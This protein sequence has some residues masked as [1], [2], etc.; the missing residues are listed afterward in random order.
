MK[1][2][3]KILSVL[4]TIYVPFFLLMGSIRIL[5]NPFFLDHEYGL[6]TFPADDFGFTTV[7]RLKWGKLSLEYLINNESDEY[8]GT[9]KFDRW[10][11]AV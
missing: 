5:I 4:V 10:F 6:P 2:L 11:P 1:I 9:L 7:D 8:L 3:V